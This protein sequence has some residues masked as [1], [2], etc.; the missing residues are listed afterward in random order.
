MLFHNR[1]LNYR[2]QL[3]F[4]FPEIHVQNLTSLY[5]SVPKINNFTTSSFKYIFHSKIFKILY[6][7]KFL[8]S[9]LYPHLHFW[10]E[11]KIDIIQNLKQFLL[12][13]IATI[14]K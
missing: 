12:F 9:H 5:Y 4:C 6:T 2:S 3:D 10:S 7:I 11:M 1:H 8:I 13:L 14:K